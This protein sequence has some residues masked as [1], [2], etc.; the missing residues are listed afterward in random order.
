MEIGLSRP[1]RSM[2]RARSSIVL[3][4]CPSPRSLR[5]FA[6]EMSISSTGISVTSMNPPLRS[7]AASKARSSSRRN[8]ADAAILRDDE[9]LRD[10][11]R[12][13]VDVA[14]HAD[15]PFAFSQPFER[16]EDN[17]ERLRI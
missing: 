13:L 17:L 12:E 11:L 8:R 4:T 15:H 9:S 3:S 5:V 14:D 16:V 2:L 6:S 10:A 7:P 1:C